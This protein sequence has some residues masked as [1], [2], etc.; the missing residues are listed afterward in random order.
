MAS[1]TFD[2]RQ[3]LGAS[4]L[5]LSSTPAV[6]SQKNPNGKLRVGV[7][8]VGNR[9]FYLFKEFQRIEGLEIA[10]VCDIYEGHLAR[11]KEFAVNQQVSFVKE[12][13]KVVNDPS[14]DAVVIATPD[15][16]HAPMTLAA[17]RAKK[18]VYIE[19]P[20]CMTVAEAR[21]LR[22]AVKQSGVKMQLGH[23]RNSYPHVI[24]AR[25]IYRSGRLGATPLI[26]TFI[27]RARPRPPWKFYGDAAN[28]EMPKDASE[29]TIDW[30]RFIAAAPK[31]RPFN[32]EEFFRW[33]GWWDY[34][35]GIADDLMSHLW[36]E[37]NCIAGMGIPE[38]C[39][40]Q[41][42]CYFWKDE[43]QVPDMWH[44][45]FDYPRKQLTITF[46]SNFVNRHVGDLAQFLG[47]DG[48]LDVTPSTC[49]LYGAEWKDE[50]K[51]SGGG[52]KGPEYTYKKGELQVSSHWQNFVDAIRKN[53]P[54]RCDED[55][56]FEEAVTVIMSIEAHHKKREVRWDFAKEEIV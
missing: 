35:T 30:N 53:E 51:P 5:T 13:E 8:G 14:L 33:R 50:E 24:K 47:R 37:T 46:S 16:W 54:L 48:T 36:D 43:I 49:R 15:F 2:R 34:S 31:R 21:Q 44:T 11:A 6:L 7:I 45:I 22:A 4:G 56:S 3:F 12:W 42:S 19:K 55:R 10:V 18:H 29:R 32:A 40:A 23:N 20:W 38:T 39:L 41:G 28:Y 26:R 9:G 52:T 17:A 1:D 25:E 27:D